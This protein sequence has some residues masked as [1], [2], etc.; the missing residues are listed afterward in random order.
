[1]LCFLPST[2]CVWRVRHESG[3]GADAVLDK[4]AVVLLP[5]CHGEFALCSTDTACWLCPWRYHHIV[6]LPVDAETL[7]VLLVNTLCFGGGRCN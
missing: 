2:L 5:L 7:N 1:M 3:L 4:M 6:Q